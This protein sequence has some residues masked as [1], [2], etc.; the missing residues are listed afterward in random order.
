MDGGVGFGDIAP[1]I[2]VLQSGVF[3][4][5]AD[6]NEDGVVD[7]GDIPGFIAILQGQ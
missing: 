4:A 2:A 1:F 5:E 3:Q 7:F 6:T